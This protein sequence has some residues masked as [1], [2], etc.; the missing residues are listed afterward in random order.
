RWP[1]VRG[2]PGRM[3]V[4]CV[5]GW[6]GIRTNQQSLLMHVPAAAAKRTQLA[7]FVVIV[8]LGHCHTH[9]SAPGLICIKANPA[10]F[11]SRL[12]K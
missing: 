9:L 1:D 2:M 5:A 7:G 11:N 4:D 8:T 6:R 10:Y 12:I 3:S